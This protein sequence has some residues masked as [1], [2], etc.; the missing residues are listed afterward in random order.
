MKYVITESGI[1]VCILNPPTIPTTTIIH[2]ATVVLN[3]NH[4]SNF[5]LNSVEA[6]H[7]IIVAVN[8]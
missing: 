5:V 1:I 7:E 6:S 8:A 3:K 2:D 4:K